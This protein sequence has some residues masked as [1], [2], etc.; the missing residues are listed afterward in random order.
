[1]A[2]GSDLDQKKGAFKKYQTE[3]ID[4]PRIILLKMSIPSKKNADVTFDKWT[5]VYRKR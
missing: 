4:K 3:V 1:M 5:F 2:V